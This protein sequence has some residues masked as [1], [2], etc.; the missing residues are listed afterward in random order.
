MI[1]FPIR[2][3][4]KS[5]RGAN[6]KKQADNVAHNL[7]A[8]RVARHLNM[9]VANDPAENQVHSFA[10][11]AI[12]LGVT[13]ELVRSAISDGGYNGITLKVTPADRE[14]LEE[15]RTERKF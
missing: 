9:L 13:V 5:Y 8:Q 2:A 7:A 11:M 3:H 10:S 14:K 1:D 6:P 4:I 15:F 12:D